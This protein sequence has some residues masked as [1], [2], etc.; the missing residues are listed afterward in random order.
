MTMDCAAARALL[1]EADPA[2]LRGEGDSPLAAHL[3]TCADCRAAADAILAGEA[4]LDA[5]L[6]TLARPSEGSRVIPL[7]PR[8]G[9]SR[10]IA[11]AAVSFAALAAA[12]AGVMLARPAAAPRGASTEQIARLMFPAPPVARAEA[13]RS[14][15]ILQTSDPGVTVVWVY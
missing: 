2:E 13:G 10:R 7:R 15:A 6:R 11:P 9:W 1:L 5:A 3:R 4:E 14:V 12:V 8:H